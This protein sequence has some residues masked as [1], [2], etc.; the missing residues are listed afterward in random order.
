[1]RRKRITRIRIPLESLTEK[2]REAIKGQVGGCKYKVVVVDEPCLTC[3][4]KTRLQYIERTD[5]KR[6]LV[7]ECLYCM[8]G[9]HTA[10]NRS[11]P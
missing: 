3:G 8:C 1:M 10:A 7:Q 6:E 4:H 11:A 5:G 2:E 9:F